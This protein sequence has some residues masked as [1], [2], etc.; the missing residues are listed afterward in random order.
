MSFDVLRKEFEEILALEERAR[1][2][3]EHYI[4]QVEDKEIKEKLTAIRNDEVMHADIAKK[5]IEYVL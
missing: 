5:L 3:Y 4:E 1:Y 2:F